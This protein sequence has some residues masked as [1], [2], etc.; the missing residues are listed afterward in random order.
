MEKKQ[1]Y[2]VQVM[3]VSITFKM[4]GLESAKGTN[5]ALYEK[6]SPIAHSGSNYWPDSNIRTWLNSSDE[7]V[8]WIK[9]PLNDVINPYADEK[10]LCME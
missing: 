7:K 4:A 1:N 8:K 5:M 9:C 3:I 10:G 2:C 6:T